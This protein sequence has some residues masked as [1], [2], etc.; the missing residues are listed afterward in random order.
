M[1]KVFIENKVLIFSQSPVREAA[2]M[3]MEVL[4]GD[5]MSLTKLLQNLQFTKCLNVVAG[6]IETVFGNFLL[7]APLIEAA[8]GLVTNPDGEILMILRSCKWDL[9]KGKLELGERIESCA[10]REVMEECSVSGIIL[11]DFITNTYHCYRVGGQWVIKQT[12][13]YRMYSPVKQPAVPQRAEGIIKAEWAAEEKL[14]ELLRMTYPNIR[15]VFIRAGYGNLI[16]NP[17]D[18]V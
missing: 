16:S 10:V 14:P 13:W 15:E 8:G 1:F 5:D 11:G 9:P 18:L 17:Q 3:V 7:S 4:G 12:W 2:P 6:D